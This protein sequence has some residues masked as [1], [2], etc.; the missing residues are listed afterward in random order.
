MAVI[1]AGL[2]T[3]RDGDFSVRLP[4][5]WTGLAGKVADTFNEIVFANQQIAQELK[6]VGQA[7]GKEG[8]P[9]AR[10]ILRVSRRVG[11][12]GD[13][14]QHARRGSSPSDHGT[15]SRDRCELR[16][17]RFTP[18]AE[19][20]LNFIPADIGRRLGEVR[21]NIDV[22]DLENLVGET[23]D[24]AT[25]HEREVREQTGAW[26]LLR[27]RPYKTWDNKIDGAVLTF[28]DIDALKRDLDLARKYTDALLE[29][30]RE[31][32]LVLDADLRVVGA[33]PAFFRTFKPN[34]QDLTGRYFYQIDEGRWNLPKLRSL[35]EDTTKR[36]SRTDDFEMHISSNHEDRLMV[37]NARRIDGEAGRPL[38]LLAIEDDT[39]KRK[40]ID[41]VRMQAAMLEL[42]HDAVLVRSLDGKIQFW[43]RGAEEMYGWTKEE[44][45]GKMKQDPLQPK[46]PKSWKNSKANY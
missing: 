34:T 7:V 3:M 28:L 29:T 40:Q 32:T 36:N 37:I 41:A 13:F 9:R 17:R 2:Q 23:I 39:E 31:S 45:L 15:A 43:N 30:A 26:H 24:T 18:A 10:Q 27:V 19:K 44:A 8:N 12:N 20:L 46:L 4:G 35:L 21:P 1:L 6:R 5:Y 42:A 38:I 14:C 11:R 16:M 33:N 25:L 22:D